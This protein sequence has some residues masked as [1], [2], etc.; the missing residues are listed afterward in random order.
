ME[1]NRDVTQAGN[2][3]CGLN[4]HTTHLIRLPLRA[5]TLK[6]VHVNKFHGEKENKNILSAVNSPSKSV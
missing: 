1:D 2:F 3:C 5:M 6:K 4:G